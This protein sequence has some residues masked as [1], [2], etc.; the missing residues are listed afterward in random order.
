[1]KNKPP[2]RDAVSDTQSYVEF[3]NELGEKYPE[4]KIVHSEKMRYNVILHELKRFALKEKSLLDIGCNDGVYTIPYCKMG[5]G[6]SAHGIDIYKSL[7][8]K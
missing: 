3:Y 5:G 2:V 4:T 8:L 6:G 7:I 1:M